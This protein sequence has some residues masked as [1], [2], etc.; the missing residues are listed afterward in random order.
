MQKQSLISQG[1][2]DSLKKNVLLSPGRV[3]ASAF[4]FMESLEKVIRKTTVLPLCHLKNNTAS[5]PAG[6]TSRLMQSNSSLLQIFTR[7]AFT[8][9]ELLV[10]IA[11]IAILAAILLPALNSARERGRTASCINNLKQLGFG[12]LEYAGA[13]DD[14]VIPEQ[15][16]I[17][18]GS[19]SLAA[20]AEKLRWY[21]YMAENN[22][23]GS[24]R[25]MTGLYASQMD[26]E[27]YFMETMF[28]PSSGA[29]TSR[30]FFNYFPVAFS[31]TYNGMLS[32]TWGGTRTMRK[33]SA[34]SRNVSKT[35]VFA[36]DWKPA[37]KSY[38]NTSYINT[39]AY[40]GLD[41]SLLPNI[42]SNGAHGR[43]ANQLFLDG[44]VEGLEFF[45]T[46]DDGTLTD[47][48]ALWLP[49]TVKQ[50]QE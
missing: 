45:Y 38:N 46:I 47:S 25:K 22:I 15:V 5:L 3:K 48:L 50:Y 13:N 9:I 49:G 42:G 37:G 24:S 12:Y 7:S 27:G 14:S 33:L 32:Y 4:N 16:K 20:S 30:S 17:P 1:T 10:V 19:S 8:L 29:I 18:Q 39:I 6:H 41:S 28:C 23:G 35:M 43:N 40:L 26:K 11:I 31:Y 2:S 21:E 34:A 36:D 44:H